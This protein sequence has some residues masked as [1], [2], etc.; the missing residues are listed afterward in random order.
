MRQSAN[1][2]NITDVEDSLFQW[3]KTS[4]PGL[5]GILSDY[6]TGKSTLLRRLKYDLLTNTVDSPVPLLF[7]LKMMNKFDSL[8]EYITFTV[9]QNLNVNISDDLFFYFA[10]SGLFVFLL[11]GFD[12]VS[13][14]FDRNLRVGAMLKLSPLLTTKSKVLLTCRPNYFMSIDEYNSV[15]EETNVTNSRRLIEPMPRYPSL[16]AEA[17]LQIARDLERTLASKYKERGQSQRINTITGKIILRP[18]THEQIEAYLEGRRSEFLEKGI[19]KS[20]AQI[21]DFLRNIY[22]INDLMTRPILLSMIVDTILLGVIKISEQNMRIGASLLYEIYTHTCFVRDF[23]KST[24]TGSPSPDQRSRFSEMLAMAMLLDHSDSVRFSRLLEMA[25]ELKLSSDSGTLASLSVER[26]AESIR[27]TTFLEHV[28]DDRFSFKHYSFVEFF[29]ARWIKDALF[30]ENDSHLQSPFHEVQLKDEILYF[31]GGFGVEEPQL[32][33]KWIAIQREMLGRTLVEGN[34]KALSVR[35]ALGALLYSGAGLR[36]RK[37]YGGYAWDMRP[38]RV[39]LDEV[40][41]EEVTLSRIKFS[42]LS[43]TLCK[44]QGVLE[45]CEFHSSAFQDTSWDFE[46]K[47]TTFDENTFISS[48]L[49]LKAKDTVLRSCHFQNSNITLEGEVNM[50]GIT[51]KNANLNLKFGNYQLKDNILE[52]SVVTQA[53]DRSQREIRVGLSST[54]F[55]RCE[56]WGLTLAPS[57]L[58][59]IERSQRAGSSQ[60]RSEVHPALATISSEWLRESTGLIF[61]GGGGLRDAASE[62]Y[63]RG[64][65]DKI[66]GGETLDREATRA[67]EHFSFSAMRVAEDSILL[68]DLT[69]FESFSLYRDLVLKTLRALKIRLPSDTHQEFFA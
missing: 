32:V 28:G 62:R 3:L 30:K 45:N 15:L 10:N 55:R 11:D 68:V 48:N 21:V 8:S 41:F 13:S 36:R 50:E 9:L 63:S 18:F 4:G 34:P 5:I 69:L 1:S 61:V 65:L 6:G 57:V 60:G 33:M 39:R 67:W 64:T 12:E 54:V 47:L 2:G 29:C 58:A 51:F 59:S 19:T 20:P 25:D 44:A 23:E 14:Q 26:L 49:T 38:E 66:K 56:I 16:A 31:L 53:R 40:E 24:G 46:T 22:D 27:Y 35:N 7:E 17:R 52:A 42:F 43:A 37:V